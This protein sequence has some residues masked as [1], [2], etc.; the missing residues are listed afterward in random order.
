MLVTNEIDKKRTTIMNQ[1]NEI[2]QIINKNIEINIAIHEYV[3]ISEYNANING[4]ICRKK[5]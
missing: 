3:I 2:K 1:T 5:E 4:C